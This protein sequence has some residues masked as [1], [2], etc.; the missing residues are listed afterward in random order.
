VSAC[1]ATTPLGGFGS[2]LI[3]Q[4]ELDLTSLAIWLTEEG[5]AQ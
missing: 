2:V 1:A 5:P 3:T 4:A